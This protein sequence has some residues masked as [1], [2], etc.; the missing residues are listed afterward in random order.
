MAENIERVYKLLVQSSESV[1]ELDRLNSSLK[2]TQDELSN[3]GKSTNE[4]NKKLDSLGSGFSS[5]AKS[6]G[7]LFGAYLTGSAL[8]SFGRAIIETSDKINTLTGSFKALGLASQDMLTRTFEI[9]QKTGTGFDDTATAVQKL[10]IGMKELGST[11]QQIQTVAETF[12]KIGRL[13]GSN[14]QAVTG[15]LTQFSQALASGKLQGDELKSI[16][17]TMPLLAQTL[18]KE[19]NTSVGELKALGAEGKITSDVLVNSLL[20]A[21]EDVNKKFAEL[22]ETFETSVNKMNTEVT[23]FNKILDDTLGLSKSISNIINSVTGLIKSMSDHLEK[24]KG[25]A[26]LL[27]DFLVGVRETLKLIDLIVQGVVLG[28][29]GVA[30]WFNA[31]YLTAIKLANLDF[32]NVGEF[33]DKAEEAIKGDLENF[34]AAVNNYKIGVEPIKDVFDII[35]NAERATPKLKDPIKDLGNACKKT[36]K[37][38]KELKEEL[39]PFLKLMDDMEKKAGAKNLALEQLEEMANIDLTKFGFSIEEVTKKTEELKKASGTWTLL[40]QAMKDVLDDQKKLED[41]VKT[42]SDLSIALA[43]GKIDRNTFDALLESLQKV[44]PYL[45]DT[46]D[47]IDTTAKKLEKISTQI[48]ASVATSFN[49]LIDSIGEAKVSF[50]DFVESFLKDLAKLIV[51]MQIMVPLAE[52]LKGAFSPTGAIGSV[53]GG[54]F[55]K[56]GAFSK[57]TGLAHGVY[58]T[59]TIFPLMEN[60][61]KAFSRGATFG[62]GLM[63][64]SGPEAVVPLTRTA[65]GD[66]GVTAS[67]VNVNVYNNTPSEVTVQSK[68]NENGSV[69]VAVMVNEAVRKEMRSGGY[70][71]MMKNNYGVQRRGF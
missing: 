15:A 66:L 2:K 38:V 43:A 29:K 4:T 39:T 32:T 51:Q 35:N 21:A 30:A 40:D 11:N 54:F 57:S 34:K 16:L 47:N 17:E 45:K 8:L 69:D 67:P 60:Q 7:T 25:Q 62:V 56:G 48:T 42:V 70:D 14:M 46:N 33:F 53:I 5:L 31:A 6:A 49:T 37:E 64:E 26:S 27:N 18:A 23:R 24:S 12:I 61:F 36:A 68:Q 41:Y 22:P 63:A 71:R 55:S 52:A 28:V 19:M 3:V 50:S 59:P 10:A 65:S 20:K 13:G 58:T 44:N 1:K 9:A